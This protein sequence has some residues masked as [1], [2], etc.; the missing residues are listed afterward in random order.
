[1][2]TTSHKQTIIIVL[3]LSICGTLWAEMTFR[4]IPMG[5]SNAN[6]AAAMARNADI[7]RSD[8]QGIGS[9]LSE[10]VETSR[11]SSRRQMENLNR[12]IVAVRQ[13]DGVFVSWRLFGTEPDG[14]AFNL[15]RISDTDSPVKVNAKP[16]AGATNYVDGD[17]NSGQAVQYFV[18][19]VL[20]GKEMPPSKPVRVWE[21][22]YLEIPIKPIS[23]YRPGDA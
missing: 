21:D 11:P 16:I 10:N 6:S 22:D 19:P 1:M 2:K 4:E 12:G 20:K 3:T 5:N 9:H 18:R 23:G 13:P 15:Y 7:T 14:T 17:T 8:S